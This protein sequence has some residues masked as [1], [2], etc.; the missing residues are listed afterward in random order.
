MAT[1][2][3]KNQTTALHAFNAKSLWTHELEHLLLTHGLDVIVHS[4]KDMPTQLPAGCILGAALNRAERRDCVAMSPA[5]TRAGKTTLADLRPGEV[6]GTSSVRRGAQVR[7]LFPHL[8]VKDVRGNV[9]SRLQK[10]DAEGGEYGCLILAA[11]GIQRVGRGDRVSSFLSR[12]EGG[13]LGAVGQGALGVEIRQGDE[14]VEALMAGLMGEGEGREAGERCLWECLA[15]RSMLRTLEGGCSVPIGVETEWIDTE[16]GEGGGIEGFTANRNGARLQDSSAT[17][18]KSTLSMHAI[19]LSVDG[20][21]AISGS[22]Q[23]AINSAEDADT[24]GW[25][26]AQELVQKGAGRILE[27]I[28]LNRKIIAEG[29]GA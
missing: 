16:N 9:G 20:S 29:D 11:T 26:M 7:R 15:E 10:L 23:Q 1:M 17:K 6:V 14:E 25:Q 18:S 4:L 13:W 8:V 19:V 21:E 24:F 2:G 5:N 28:T 22:M 12:Q 27:A 3:D